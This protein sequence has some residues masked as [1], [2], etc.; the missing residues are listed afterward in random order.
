MTHQLRELSESV[1]LGT[2]AFGPWSCSAHRPGTIA[3]PDQLHAGAIEWLPATGPTTVAEVLRANGRWNHDAP[4]DLDAHDWWFRTTLADPG[5]DRC[6]L[7]FDGL[8]TIAEVW[9]N[10]EKILATDNMFRS[11][12]VDVSTLLRDENELVLGFRSLTEALKQKRPRPRWKTNLVAQ[13]QLRWHRTT[14]LG[15]IPGWAPVAPAVGPWRGVRIDCSTVALEDLGLTTRLEGDTGVVTVRGLLNS[16]AKPQSV[17]LRVGEAQYALALRENERGWTVAGEARIE[18]A[19]RWWPRTHGA[20]ERLACEIVVETA[21][22]DHVV[23]R[24]NIGFRQLDMRA[25]ERF[26]VRI[27]GEPIY[28]RGACWTVT[29]LVSLAGDEASLRR[30]LTLARDAGMNMLRVGGT[31]TYENDL[32]YELC[33]ELG[34]MVWQDF[35]FA[36][37]DYPVDDPAFLANITAEAREQVARLAAHA[38]V[39]VY[40]GNSEIE[41]QAAMLGMPRE[42]WRNVWFAEQLPSLVAELHPNTAY[43]PSTP[44]GGTLP[45]HTREGV[46]HYY[47]VGAYLRPLAELRS[48][49]VGFTPEC[50][51]FS[52]VP[53]PATTFEV[54]DGANPAAHDPR[55]KRRVPRDTGAGWDFEDVR[56][57]YLRELYSVDPVALRSFQMGRYLQLGRTATGEMMSRAFAEWRSTHSSNQGALV[58][59][60]KDLWAGAGWGIVDAAGVPKAAYYH[61]KR[62]WQSRQLTM[63][64]EGINGLDLHLTNETALACDATLEVTLLKEPNLVIAH[65]RSDIHVDARGKLRRSVDEILGRFY[66]CN[67]AYRFGP[68]H[69]DVV[70]ATWCDAERQP[71]SEA[72]HFIHRREPQPRPGTMPEAIAERLDEATVRLSLRGSEFLHAV[73]LDAEGWLPDDNY[74]HLPPERAKTAMFRPIAGTPRSFR[75]TVEALNREE[76]VSVSAAAAGSAR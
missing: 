59:F 50:L 7:C 58:W 30:D 61:L 76:S 71:I 5:T 48:A 35:M 24:A 26:A 1:D 66:D 19:P 64:D 44:S 60:Y 55:W 27:N 14:L 45:F 42:L 43:V 40:C 54:F 12:R 18:H 49:D 63:T 16:I 21:E 20:P 73:H 15:R 6:V 10:G 34:I 17:W 65:G 13:Q 39:V 46:T 4:L 70:I 52:N 29:D 72:F 32:F 25:G 31:M 2:T 69:H 9:L 8:V 38:S 67:Y 53:E 51:G 37:M 68:P 22:A 28:C 36:N 56:D 23:H 47:G 11:H 62:A 74:F 57:H 3:H 33:D 41:Q 75:C